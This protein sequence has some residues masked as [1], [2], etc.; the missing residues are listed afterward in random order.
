ME[1]TATDKYQQIRIEEANR[2]KWRID[3]FDETGTQNVHVDGRL[4]SCETLTSMSCSI[5]N[6]CVGTNGYQGGDGGHGCRT[7]LSFEEQ[8]CGSFEIS[9]DPETQQLNLVAAGDDELRT[10]I[11]VLRFA[12][13]TLEAQ[14]GRGDVK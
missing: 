11:K 6:V 10:L 8:G 12:A 9:I 5:T 7:Y 14:S 1:S 2:A 13:D 4:I 3:G